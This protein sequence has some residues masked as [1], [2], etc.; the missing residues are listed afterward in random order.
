M[1]GREAPSAV[2]AVEPRAVP[3]WVMAVSTLAVGAI[4]GLGAV[5]FRGMIAGFHNLFFLGTFSFSYDANVHTPESPFGLLVLFAPIVGALGVAFLVKT[6]A[7]E[8][9]GHGVPEVMSAIYH[10]DGRIRPVVAAIKSLASALSIGS[11]GSVGREGPIIQIGSAFG[12]TMGQIIA[13]PVR[14]RAVLIAA[15]AGGGIAAT[16]NTPIGGVVFAIE[17]MLPVASSFSIAYVALACVVATA[18]GRLSFGALPPLDVPSIAVVETAQSHVLAL[19][20]F[21]PFGLLIGCAAAATSRGIYWFEDL[22][23]RMPGNYYTRHA[24]GMALVGL[25]IVGFM[26]LSS[27]WLGQPDHYYIQGV[28]YATI[29]DVLNGTLTSIGFLVLLA[30][31]K[32]LATC[33][34]LGSGASGG[35]FSPCMFLGATLGAAVGGVAHA[36]APDLAPSPVHF[37]IAGM[38]G[39][40]GGTTGAALTATIMTFEMTRDYTVALPIIVTVALATAIR[41]ALSPTTIYTMKL[42]R[43]GEVVPQGLSAWRG[44]TRVLDIMARDVRVVTSVADASPASESPVV[45]VAEGGVVQAVLDAR[46]SS[47]PIP[48]AIVSPDTPLQEALRRMDEARVR[49]LVAVD[50]GTSPPRVVGI[51]TDRE[52]AAQAVRDARLAVR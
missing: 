7:P 17:L 39:M 5:V 35:V 14:Q 43:R 45:L 4:A 29:M 18:I 41:Y 15:G 30:V 37:A 42:W 33:L 46:V 23:D 49:A 16:F 12:S 10:H 50:D 28:G 20:W 3:W 13:M 1:A 19:P 11:G 26:S 2:A 47:Q 44:E 48:C 22:F 40:V 51:V 6:F 27:A 38:A 36:I 34:T 21:V 9:K 32:L 8:A 25:M 52:V 31:A 24:T